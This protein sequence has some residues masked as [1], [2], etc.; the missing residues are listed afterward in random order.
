MTI[1]IDGQ[2]LPTAPR[3]LLTIAEVIAITKAGRRQV[4]SWVQSGAL[5]AIKLGRAL[6]VHPE[7]LEA[8]LLE[9]RTGRGPAA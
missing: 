4:Y 2:P 5:P 6:R 8:F 9:R 7:D 3:P 1:R